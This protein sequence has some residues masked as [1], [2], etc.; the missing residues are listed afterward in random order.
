MNLDFKNYKNIII[1]IEKLKKQKNAIILAH[2][3]QLPEVQDV[4]DYVGDSYGLSIAAQNSKSDIIVFA[5][6]RFM[7]ETAKILNPKTKVLLPEKEASCSL[8][9]SCSADEF[10]ETLKNYPNH[11]VVTYINSSIEIKSLSHICCTSSNAEKIINKIPKDKEIYF[12]PDQNLAKYLINKTKRK[13]EYWKGACHV[14]NQLHVEKVLELKSLHQDALLVSHP[15]CQGP[16]LSISDFV[17]STT[18]IID[19]CK[20]SLNNKFIIATETGILHKLKKQSAEKQFIIVP[21]DESCNCNDCNFMKMIT[22]EKIYNSLLKEENEIIIEEN[23]RKQALIP[24][25]EM[26]KLTQ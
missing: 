13:M 6:V 12:A 14:H 26:I 2:Y 3:Y 15:E 16:I 1:E 5:G 24:I 25:Q 9:D 23:L 22:L 17:G 8:A 19:Y 18:Q 20:N 21:A 11:V 10:K 4:A 7:A